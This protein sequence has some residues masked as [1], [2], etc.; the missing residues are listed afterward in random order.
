MYLPHLDSS[1]KACCRYER[2]QYSCSIANSVDIIPL[3]FDANQKLNALWKSGQI[4]EARQLFDKIPNRDEFTWNTM[5]AAY[6]S[7]GR[8][9]EA[10]QLF[11]ETPKRSSI[12]WSSLISGYCRYAH[13]TETLQ[14][15]L[16][17][18]VRGA[19]TYY[20]SHWEV[21]LECA[22]RIFCSQR[23]T[24]PCLCH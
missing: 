4:D 1:L 20:S 16:A 6:S 21:F 10:R 19:Q 24:N 8:L 23:G 2:I 15:F 11:D 22:R 13:E 3:N 5:I 14:L 12:T 17:D 9:V 7:S 18:A